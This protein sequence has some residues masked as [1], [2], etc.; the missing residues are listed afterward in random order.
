MGSSSSA[1]G[2]GLGAATPPPID[3]Q[4]NVLSA[5]TRVLATAYKAGQCAGAHRL[6]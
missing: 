4:I 1:A 3:G 2:Q 6:T 5:H